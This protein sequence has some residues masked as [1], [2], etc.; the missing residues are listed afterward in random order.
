MEALMR[1]HTSKTMKLV[2]S[3][4]VFFFI[5]LSVGIHTSLADEPKTENKQI[6]GEA[7]LCFPVPVARSLLTEIKTLR[8]EKEVEGDLIKK[9]L[10]IKDEKIEWYK[11]QHIQL[12][13]AKKDAFLSAAQMEQELKVWHGKHATQVLDT[14]KYKGE[15]YQFLVWGLVIGAGVATVVFVTIGIVIA[16]K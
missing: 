11:F 12:D 14:A 13:K 5:W 3:V 1:T 4:V 2:C 10:K 9:Q 7:H 16:V 8:F 6:K 15:R